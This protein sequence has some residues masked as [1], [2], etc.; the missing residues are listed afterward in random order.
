[1]RG[2][3]PEDRKEE[4]M[5][6]ICGI[7]VKPVKKGDMMLLSDTSVSLERGLHNDVRGEGGKDRKRQVT[8]VSFEQWIETCEDMGMP[9]ALLPWYVRRAN[10]CVRGICFQK[11][12]IGR[13]L[14][15]GEGVV[16]EIT[17][18][19]DPCERMEAIHAGLRD[20]LSVDM[21]GGVSCRV[22]SGGMIMLGGPVGFTA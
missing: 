18:E 17:Q 16:L 20:V 14:M 12:D 7:A 19:T 1:M 15:L 2:I 10:I 21:R 4:T 11:A 5:A 8:L 22:L 3:T 6:S 9:L 13:K